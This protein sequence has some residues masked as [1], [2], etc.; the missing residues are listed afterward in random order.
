MAEPEVKFER[1]PARA[2][3]RAPPAQRA[4]EERISMGSCSTQLVFFFFFFLQRERE[5]KKVR[6]G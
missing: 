4:T 6:R 3:A 5:G 2:A 1:E